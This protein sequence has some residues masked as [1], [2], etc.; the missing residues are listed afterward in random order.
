MQHFRETL[1]S[2]LCMAALVVVLFA[3]PSSP[4]AQQSPD[5]LVVGVISFPPFIQTDTDGR[6]SGY[7]IDLA[8]EIAD[9]IDVP[10]EFRE[11][12]GIGPFF[13]AQIQGETHLMAGVAALPPLLATNTLSQPIAKA[14]VRIAVRSE[15]KT[16]HS[17]GPLSGIRLGFVP[18]TVGADE[19]AVLDQNTAVEFSS[20]DSAIMG[21]LTKTVDALLIAE[22]AVFSTARRGRLD[23]RIALVGPPV[24]EFDRVVAVHDSRKDLQPAINEAIARISADGRLSDLRRKYFLELPPLAPDVLRVGVFHFPPFQVVQE[25]GSFTGLSVENL[26]ELASRAGIAVSFE[27][28]TLDQWREGPQPGSYDMLPQVGV[29]AERSARMDFSYPVDEASFS[30]FTRVGEA[31]GIASL[32]DLADR[33]VGV[34]QANLAYRIA[35]EHGNLDLILAKDPDDLLETLLD[36][37]SDAILYPTLH[38]QTSAQKLGVTDKIHEVTPPFF[39][40][41]RAPALRVGLGDIRERLNAVTPGYL[42][43]EERDAL[44]QKWLGE[45]VFWT[46]ERI[47]NA[48]VMAAVAVALLI[49]GFIGVL[50]LRGRAEINERRRFAAELVDQLPFGLLHIS[51]NGKVE[52]ANAELKTRTPKGHEVFERGADYREAVRYLIDAGIIATGDV[53]AD[54]M[55]KRMAVD[56]LQDG[57]VEEYRL[58]NEGVFLRTTKHL[59]DGSIL[60]T[61]LDLT[62]EHRRLREIED[63]NTKLAHQITIANV[64]N[65]DLRSFAYSTSHDLKAP[66]NTMSMLIDELSH[67]LQG[68][69]SQDDSELLVDL[70]A[71][72]QKMGQLIEDVLDYTSAIGSETTFTEVDL[73]TV[74]DDVLKSLTADIE[75]SGAEITRKPLGGL[76]ANPAQMRQLLQ[77]LISNAIKFRRPDDTPQIEISP[78]EAPEGEIS[79]RVVDKG[80]GIAPE[81]EDRLFKVFSR[82]H[83]NAEYQGTGMGLAICQRVALNHGGRIVLSS[84]PGH[85]SC[86]T[87]TLKV[88]N[89]PARAEVARASDFGR[90]GVADLN[91]R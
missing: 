47:R 28:I 14:R 53:G 62:E 27:E 10:I 73:N 46:P 38:I 19:K 64:A 66:T 57:C 22:V 68:N 4:W 33:K 82:L 18:P 77:N 72:S 44:R 34:Q 91:A 67:S 89:A 20:T 74:L 75:Q 36:G 42:I 69:V 52:F 50:F 13:Q 15:D 59:R 48:L 90:P 76:Q 31:D 21:L 7:M 23:H 37:R 65:D 88:R 32:D 9:E 84:E 1:V 41:Q 63:L 40:S 80:I 35:R 12:D 49:L 55:F 2:R 58:E 79:F 83:N 87:I 61:R 51:R 45:T 11:F 54:Q 39:I 5:P 25:D 81:H 85:G 24:R 60:I 56:G 70:K 8:R 78:V 3:A 86:F 26:R 16:V 43:S 6:R 17:E 29:D 30:I 71:T